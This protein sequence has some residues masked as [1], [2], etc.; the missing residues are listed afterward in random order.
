MANIKAQANGNWSATATW[1]GGV[2]PVA[3]DAVWANN[4]TIT[5]NQDISVASLNTT[6]AVGILFNGGTMTANAGGVFNA[7]ALV[8]NITATDITAGSS[9]VIV[10]QNTNLALTITSSGSINGSSTTNGV[11]G[12]IYGGSG[13]CT[14]S[15][16]IINS[17]T[18]AGTSGAGISVS[19]SAVGSNLTITGSVIS[20]NTSALSIA[21]A[22]TTTFTGTLGIA[23]G[24]TT[25]PLAISSSG[26]TTINADIIVPS[27][28]ANAMATINSNVGTINLV[29]TITANTSVSSANA[30]QHNGTAT[31]NI[32]GNCTGG[33]VS[34]AG[35]NNSG[36]GTINIYGICTGG[37]NGGFGAF[38][39]STGT[40]SVTRARGNGFG[41]GSV[42][43]VSAAGL[44]SI[45]QASINIV[46]ELEF[47]AL[48]MSPIG[49][50][51]VRLLPSTSNV[52][53]FYTST[54]GT[55]TLSDPAAVAGTYPAT[56]DVRS[57][58]TYAN[59]NS[60]GTL[61]VPA[62]GSVALGVPVDNTTG[63]A[64]LTAANVQTALTS[65]GYTT[66]RAT[67]LD[68]LDA[69]ISSRSTLTPSQVTAAVLPI[70]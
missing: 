45:N 54:G 48:G 50:V 58:T 41:L 34:S 30:V 55:K 6:A 27:A 42:G 19:G 24:A 11:V 63:T 60:T 4:F 9:N 21:G 12:I 52:A 22:G 66:T 29:G 13:T 32:T 15:A 25:G 35:V 5:L 37:S 67:N 2:V 28:L 59:G 46:R 61:A 70:L 40:L 20:R 36:T 68:N 39:N 16:N 69:T 31:I 38:N 49:S 10:I 8:A 14:I 43:I 23:S 57:G 1:A 64:V 62:V 53:I 17:G 47:G 44:S 3:G 18:S 7:G 56:S 51:P 33:A 65:Q 26:T